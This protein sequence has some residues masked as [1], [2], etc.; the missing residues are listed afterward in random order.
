MCHEDV[1]EC[2][3]VFCNDQSVGIGMRLLVLEELKKSFKYMSE[4][5]LILLLGN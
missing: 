2:M 3:R 1:M 4:E 5:D